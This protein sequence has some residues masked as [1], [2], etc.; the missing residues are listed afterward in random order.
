MVLACRVLGLP[1]VIVPWS[2]ECAALRSITTWR[3]CSG[4]QL[5]H[6]SLPCFSREKL[7]RAHVFACARTTLCSFSPSIREQRVQE[8]FSARALAYRGEFTRLEV[9]SLSVAAAPPVEA[10]RGCERLVVNELTE[11]SLWH[12][13]WQHR[14]KRPAHINLLEGAVSEVWTERAAAH[15][16]SGCLSGHSLF[17]LR[18]QKQ[19]SCHPCFCASP[20]PSSPSGR[21]ISCIPLRTISLEPE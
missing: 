21:S 20:C 7:G 17:P 3:P 4:F 6:V 9:L 19:P 2:E 16:W 12:T 14:R 10:K 11:S 1:L 8:G 15:C 5:S 13:V 18:R